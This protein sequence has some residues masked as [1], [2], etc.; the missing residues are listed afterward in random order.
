MPVALAWLPEPE[1]APPTPEAV[2]WANAV[3]EV[4]DLGTG[5]RVSLSGG[6]VG[7][8]LE[9]MTEEGVVIEVVLPG[10]AVRSARVVLQPSATPRP[11]WTRY[12][13][14]CHTCRLLRRRGQMVVACW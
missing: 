7:L 13:V 4:P 6:W 8:T 11:N 10:A 1:D 9:G 14:Q 3:P 12:V 5:V 2:L